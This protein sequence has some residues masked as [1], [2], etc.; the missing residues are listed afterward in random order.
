MSLQTL[1]CVDVGTLGFIGVCRAALIFEGSDRLQVLGFVAVALTVASN[2]CRMKS[3]VSCFYLARIFVFIQQFTFDALLITFWIE[4]LVI[5]EIE[6]FQFGAR[7]WY[8]FVK[9]I[10][11]T[12]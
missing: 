4:L 9:I 6:M 1:L 11:S 5:C 7:T 8:F 2:F 10:Y 3:S 12:I